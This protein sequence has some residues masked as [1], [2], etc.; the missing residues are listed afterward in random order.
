MIA[1][2]GPSMTSLIFVLAFNG[3]MVYARMTRG[4]VLSAKER[5]YVEAAEMIG[6]KPA[7]GRCSPTSCPT[8]R[9]RW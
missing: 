9:R 4:V 3:W 2:L 8:S 1:V 6:C 5:P 7:P